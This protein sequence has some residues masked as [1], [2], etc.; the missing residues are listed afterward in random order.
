MLFPLHFWFHCSLTF[1]VF[2]IPRAQA[3]PPDPSESAIQASARV[4]REYGMCGTMALDAS[5]PVDYRHW[6]S[7]PD[8]LPA[9]RRMLDAVGRRRT[10]PQRDVGAAPQAPPRGLRHE[11]MSMRL[12]RDGDV[13]GAARQLSHSALQRGAAAL[14][15][16]RTTLGNV[17]STLGGLG[18]GLQDHAVDSVRA[19]FEPQRPVRQGGSGAGAALAPPPGARRLPIPM[20]APR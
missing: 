17:P 10:F 4:N 5:L 12:L 20:M 3:N 6:R 18:R 2:Y 11:R 7:A 16:V 14:G 15:N 19:Y 8:A 1:V 13:G 9:S